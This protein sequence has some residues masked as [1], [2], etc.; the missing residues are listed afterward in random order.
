MHQEEELHLPDEAA[1]AAMD[2]MLESGEL[3]MVEHPH[4]NR[5]CVRLRL[6]TLTTK[7]WEAGFTEAAVKAISFFVVDDLVAQMVQ[8][9]EL[10]YDHTDEAG[11]VHYKGIGQTSEK[12]TSAK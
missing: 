6:E 8:D 1:L 4:T 10:E 7:D 11:E 9:G 2:F 5:R 3:V 12:P